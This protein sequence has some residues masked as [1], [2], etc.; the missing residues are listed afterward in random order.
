[1]F[2][3]LFATSWVD[4]GIPGFFGLLLLICPHWAMKKTGSEEKDHARQALARKGG[5]VLLVVA[6]IY[7]FTT[8][9]V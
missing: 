1:M 4:V 6:V 5:A 8:S 3:S 9:Q 2:P 7:F